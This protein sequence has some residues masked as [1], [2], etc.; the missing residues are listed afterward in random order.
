LISILPS[1]NMIFPNPH[2]NNI[3]SSIPFKFFL[4]IKIC[5]FFKLILTLNLL[6]HESIID[7][8]LGYLETWLH[9][10]N[11]ISIDDFIA[12]VMVLTT[13]MFVNLKL[14]LLIKINFLKIINMSLWREN[15]L[16]LQDR[17]STKPSTSG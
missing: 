8:Y 13:S 3:V 6:N 7:F 17:S 15:K 2:C 10:N 1:C 12:N 5:K 11:K 4:A 9:W 14:H 16:T